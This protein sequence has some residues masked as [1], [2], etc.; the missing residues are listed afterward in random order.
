MV[1]KK[2]PLFKPG[3]LE[4]PAVKLFKADEEFVVGKNRIGWMSE[5]FED[6]VRGIEGKN[7]PAIFM[8]S[9][10]LAREVTSKEVIRAVG[11]KGSA[12]L[13][14]LVH[15]LMTTQ[16]SFLLVVAIRGQLWAVDA[17]W[18][19]GD[20]GWFVFAGSVEDPDGWDADGRVFSRKLSG[21]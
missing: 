15:L 2:L 13:A 19:A 5:E 18:S 20:G 1:K 16:K 6:L 14:H 17:R 10:D 3:L 9:R 8:I 11:R 7:V 4:C 21:D 12:P